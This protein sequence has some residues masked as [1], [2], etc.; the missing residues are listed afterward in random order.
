M[1]LPLLK[2]FLVFTSTTNLRLRNID[3]NK[4]QKSVLLHLC[5]KKTPLTGDEVRFIRKYFS[6]TTTA[7]AELFGHT[8]SA[9]LKWENQDSDIARINPATE[10][11]IRLKILSFLHKEPSD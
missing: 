5:F 6:L 4:L 10:V 2:Y 7:F 11:Y 1:V 8:H 3:F 9:V